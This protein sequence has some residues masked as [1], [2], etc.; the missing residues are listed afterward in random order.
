MC[1]ALDCE[2]YQDEWNIGSLLKNASFK[3]NGIDR[4][5]VH[6]LKHRIAASHRIRPL[7]D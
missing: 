2:Q 7:I 5:S 3:K 1:K 4:D 6:D